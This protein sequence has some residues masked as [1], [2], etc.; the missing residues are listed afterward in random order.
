[1]V[2]S[3]IPI[4]FDIFLSLINVSRFKFHRVLYSRKHSKLTTTRR[5]GKYDWKY[6]VNDTTQG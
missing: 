4:Y 6:K 2:N 5:T 3:L 1:M